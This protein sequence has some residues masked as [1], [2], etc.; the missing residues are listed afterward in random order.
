[1]HALTIEA[2]A[3]PEFTDAGQPIGPGR[4]ERRSASGTGGQTMWGIETFPFD[5]ERLFEERHA[6]VTAAACAI[7][8]FLNQASAVKT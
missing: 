6:Q 2:L 8:E 3:L 1:M 7:I 5:L 4:K